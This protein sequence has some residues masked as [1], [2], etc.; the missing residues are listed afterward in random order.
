MNSAPMGDASRNSYTLFRPL[1]V[2]GAGSYRCDNDKEII[3]GDKVMILSGGNFNRGEYDAMEGVVSRV[4][5]G[6]AQVCFKKENIVRLN[7]AWLLS[8]RVPVRYVFK[9]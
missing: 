3:S 1:P 5:D 2:S 4:E 6:W 7:Q 8:I 9:N